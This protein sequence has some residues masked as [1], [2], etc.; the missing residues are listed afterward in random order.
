MFLRDGTIIFL[1]SEEKMKKKKSNW[2]LHERR[3]I[4]NEINKFRSFQQGSSK[5]P[6]HKFKNLE[7]NLFIFSHVAGGKWF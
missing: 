4:D 6:H 2:D 1:H 3:P 7:M 5:G